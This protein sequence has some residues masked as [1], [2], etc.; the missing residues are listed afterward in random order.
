MVDDPEYDPAALRSRMMN[1]YTGQEVN[2][3]AWYGPGQE[4]EYGTLHDAK[5]A[6][7]H[8]PAELKKGTVRQFTVYANQKYTGSRVLVQKGEKY[9]F[10]I[11]LSQT[12]FDGNMIATPLGWQ[13]KSKKAL[14]WYKK[15]FIK[16]AEDERRHPEAEWFEILGTVNRKEQ[17][18]IRITQ[19]IHETWEAEESG[20][21]YAFPNDLMSKYGNNLG[22]IQV[23]I[24]MEE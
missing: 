6:A 21:F 8:Q 22:T 17:N 24:R 13:E 5:L 16:A 2:F 1:P 4:T 3:R 20:E 23:A 12:W 10:D 19:F 7:V 9:R 11:D 18:L 14:E 15:L